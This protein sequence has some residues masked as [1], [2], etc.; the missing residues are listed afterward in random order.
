MKIIL[1]RAVERLG[2]PLD[3]VDVK[4]G[5]ARNYLIPKGLALAATKGN[6]KGLEK[7][8][9]RFSKQMRKLREVGMELSERINNLSIKTSIKIGI[10]GKSF[11][12]I[13]SQN[14]VELLE[15]ENIRIDK[16]DIVLEE[17]IKRPGVYDIK[18]HLAEGIN[19]VFKV[20]VIEEVAKS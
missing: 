15:S 9:E 13:T 3:V 5:Y 11:G 12:S 6:L 16:K 4:T 7:N 8:K 2:Q 20:A 1:L 19:A 18:V 17:P 14:L 10:D